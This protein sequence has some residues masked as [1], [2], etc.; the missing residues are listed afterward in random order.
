MS[1]IKIQPEFLKPGDKVAIVSPSFGIDMKKLSDAV[2]YLEKWGL[3]VRIG[4]NAGKQ[5]GP[6]SGSD[7]DRL[8]DLQEMTNDPEIKAVICSRGG[9]GISRIITGVDFS[10][11]KNNPK[12]YVGF[13]DITVLHLWLSEVCGIM[14]IHGDMPLN[15]GNP[16]K[17]KATFISLK[18]AL[19]GDLKPCEWKGTFFRA[20]NVKAEI[21]G[22]NLSLIYSLTGTP[23]EPDTKGKILFI[24]E[25]GEYYYHI[26]RML[27]SLKIAGKLE[28]LAALLIGGMNNITEAKV[29]WGKSI[30]ET[31]Y[32]IVSEY[33]YPVL[34]NFPAGHVAYNRAFYIGKRAKI[35]VKGGSASLIS[36]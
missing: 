1:E 33:D 3:K 9:Y 30:E 17:K 27:T 20:R 7:E 18:Q 36:G 2:P 8:S 28:G 10:A 24:E 35:D 31:I 15:F 25:V 11:L 16:E 12:W 26:D 29:P 34:F 5:I 13:S 19:F 23:A 6:F 32:G 4:K 21:T 22:G 14:S